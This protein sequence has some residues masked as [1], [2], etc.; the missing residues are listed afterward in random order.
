MPHSAKVSTLALSLQTMHTIICCHV[1]EVFEGISAHELV[2]AFRGRRLIQT[3]RKGKQLWLVLDGQGPMPLMHFGMTGF[4]AV[5][6]AAEG[7]VHLVAY[8]NA[9]KDTAANWPPRFLKLLLHFGPS[10]S[11]AASTSCELAF[12]DARR[13]GRL[14][15]VQENPAESEVVQKLGFDPLLEMPDLGAFKELIARKSRGAARLKPL[16]LDQEFCAGVGN[17]VADEVLWHARLH[18]EQPALALQPEHIEALHTALQQVVQTA[19]E[20]KADSSKYPRDWLFHVRWRKKVG[21]INGHTIDHI[22]VGS[23]TSCYVPELQKVIGGVTVHKLKPTKGPKGKK[24]K[25]DNSQP[26]TQQAEDTGSTDAQQGNQHG[27]SAGSRKHRGHGAKKAASQEQTEAPSTA[28]KVD[29]AKPAQRHTA[30][31]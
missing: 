31:Q 21:S 24:R 26:D 5:R 29:K 2:K 1:A 17:W 4:I 15:L 13:F 30:K 9:P 28:G 6:D 22:T 16:L 11:N 23:R 3:G 10:D 7:T 25:Q 27:N 8:E 14:K 19:V 18:P 12:C 20:A